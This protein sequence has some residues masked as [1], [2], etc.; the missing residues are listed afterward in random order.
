MKL[1][2]H[3][4]LTAILSTTLTGCTAVA[5]VDAVATTAVKATTT[6]VGLAA[7]GVG[8]GVKAI[9]NAGD[10]DDEE[11]KEENEE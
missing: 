1:T 2:Q 5:I 4:I 10:D 11:K 3:L 9:A 8:A 7:K 6:T